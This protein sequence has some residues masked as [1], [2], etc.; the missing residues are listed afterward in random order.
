MVK[1]E[2]T[3]FNSLTGETLTQYAWR[4]EG[5][6]TGVVQL[7]HGMAEH[8]AR[9][10]GAAQAL[11][12]AGFLVVGHTHAGHGENPR[13]KGFFG[14][15][16][17]LEALIADI[18]TVRQET[19]QAHLGKPYFLL[20]HSMG[21]FLVRRYIEEHG[22]GLS[23]AI[24]SGTAHYEKA[25]LSAVLAL[26][27]GLI[28]LGMGKKPSP[29]LQKVS[30]LG[31]NKR[32]ENSVT[33]FDWLSADEANVQRYIADAQCGFPFTAYG[34]RDLFRCLKQLTDAKRLEGIPKELP[35][36][37]FAGMEDPVGA[38]GSGV[39]LVANELRQ[40]GI[41]DVDVRL[42]K[43]GRHEMLNEQQADEVCRDLIQWLYNHL[44]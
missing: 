29:L 7:A 10:E 21:S 9:Y 33:P 3:T 30:S 32:I 42:Y 15:K 8:M 37:L 40:A 39:S 5:D 36:Y 23:G 38:Y 20:G 22:R 41:L 12:R 18:H 4:P 11:G 19:Q 31:Y 43:D 27:N 28:L 44:A 2:K 1:C 13:L 14:K 6:I 17:G 24:L 16:Q 34:Y 25:A 26:T 35:I